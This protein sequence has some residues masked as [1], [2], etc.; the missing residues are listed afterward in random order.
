MPSTPETDGGSDD[1]RQVVTAAVSD[2]SPGST[3]HLRVV[4]TDLASGQTTTG[5]GRDVRRPIRPRAVTGLAA[6]GVGTTSATVNGTADTH[7]QPGSYRFVVTSSTGPYTHEHRR[8][9]V[10]AGT[11]PVSVSADAGRPPSGGTFLVR[12]AV[13]SD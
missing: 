1:A 8:A 3:Y 6:T 10:P 2:L 12:L 4:A 5:A 9:P 11:G 7:G 13:T